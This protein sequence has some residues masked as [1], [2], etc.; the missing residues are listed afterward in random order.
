MARNLSAEPAFGQAPIPQK[1]GLLSPEPSLLFVR[2]LAKVPKSQKTRL[3]RY[4][5]FR[6]AKFAESQ[7]NH[8]GNCDNHHALRP[9]ASRS[10]RGRNWWIGRRVVVVHFDLFD[11]LDGRKL[12]I[13]AVRRIGRGKSIGPE[14]RFEMG[15]GNSAETGTGRIIRNQNFRIHG[16]NRSFPFI[17]PHWPEQVVISGY[18]SG[19][20]GIGTGVRHLRCGANS[21]QNDRY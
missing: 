21:H 18:C 14:C 20:N 16:R 9:A 6:A 5:V 10:R 11:W 1:S 4:P 13:A 2:A 8:A 7:Q 15:L 12:R 3:R 19:R 17:A